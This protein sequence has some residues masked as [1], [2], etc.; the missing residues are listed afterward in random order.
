MPLGCSAVLHEQFA[1]VGR[2]NVAALERAIQLYKTVIENGVER[3][4]PVAFL[5]LLSILAMERVG[6]QPDSAPDT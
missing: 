5:Q 3:Q 4:Q 2:G 1:F 6:L